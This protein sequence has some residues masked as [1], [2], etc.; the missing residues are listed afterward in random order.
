MDKDSDGV[1]NEQAYPN[2]SAD[3]SDAVFGNTINRNGGLNIVSDI[4]A[5]VV[6]SEGSNGTKGP[7][8]LLSQTSVNAPSSE[9]W[10]ATGGLSLPIDLPGY[11][12]SIVF[13]KVEGKPVLIV[14]VYSRD[15]LSKLLGIVW[16]IVGAVLLLWLLGSMKKFAAGNNLP[17]LFA[18]LVLLGLL[19][20]TL[21]PGGLAWLALCVAVIAG[22]LYAERTTRKPVEA[23]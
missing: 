16:V 1:S 10:T 4:N 19:G 2:Y 14:E 6:I 23:V 11:D 21:L 13:S 15:L 5:D 3:S 18:L 7:A 8:A 17:K 22:I 20:F 9:K 12:Q